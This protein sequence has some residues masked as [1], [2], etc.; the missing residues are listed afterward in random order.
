MSDLATLYRIQVWIDN[1]SAALARTRRNGVLSISREGNFML[2]I[3]WLLLSLLATLSAA[4][5]IA[6]TPAEPNWP[7]KPIKLVVPAGAGGVPD[8]R[9]RWLAE[10]I[11]PLLGQPVWIENKPGAGGNIGME[12]VAHSAPDGYTLVAMHLGTMAF[13]SFMYQRTGY[14]PLKDFIPITRNGVGPLMLI[15]NPKVP[16]KTVQE[17]VQLARSK[18]GQLS[19]SFPGFGTPPHLALELFKR[20]AK[21]DVISVPYGGGAQGMTDIVSGQITFTMEGAQL[22]IPNARAGQVRPLAVTGRSRMASLP[23]VPTLIESGYPDCEFYG[24]TG[25]AAPAG[26][27][28]VII[29]RLYA[30]MSKVLNSDEAKQWYSNVDNEPGGET[31][32]ATAAIIRTEYARWGKLI[33]EA[34]IKAE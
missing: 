20:S 31:P 13:N 7:T 6:T 12:S 18:P 15:V 27:P 11:S 9:A 5:A 34:G 1:F 17:L 8:I 19:F 16:A 25:V 2:R 4:N 30:A 10:R 28:K 21:I 23:D 14:D 32:E 22:A 3:F 33:K 29:D 24:W 26:T